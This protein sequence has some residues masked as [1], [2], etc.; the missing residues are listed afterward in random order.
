MSIVM[1]FRKAAKL[2]RSG[3]FR[4]EPG[5]LGRFTG[6]KVFCLSVPCRSFGAWVT[7][8]RTACYKHGAPLEL[9]PGA[10]TIRCTIRDAATK[11]KVPVTNDAVPKP[12]SQS[13][14][15][16]GAGERSPQTEPSLFG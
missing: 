6:P 16:S 1:T 10:S 8:A 2:R 13:S 7:S 15:R 12:V 9:A 11:P 4:R 5:G 14:R 3:I